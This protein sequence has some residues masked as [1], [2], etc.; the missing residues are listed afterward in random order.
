MTIGK[1]TSK[2]G[3]SIQGQEMIIPICVF[4]EE[5]RIEFIGTGFFIANCGIFVTA[6][7][8]I[9]HLLDENGK[10]PVDA[11]GNS[12]AGLFTFHMINPKEFTARKICTGSYH[13]R[14][15]VAVGIAEKMINSKT[16]EPLTNKFLPLTTIAPQVG[17]DISTWAY[18]K[19]VT[20]RKFI[21]KKITSSVFT[22]PKVYGGKV[23]KEHMNR[24]WG[25][26]PGRCYQTSLDFEGGSSGGPVFDKNGRVFAVNSTGMGAQDE[27]TW[28]SHIQ[29]I[30]GL[31]LQNIQ[32][33]DGV[34]HDNITIKKLIEHKVIIVDEGITND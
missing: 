28:V 5:N 12:K 20:D 14:D 4:H 30:G 32:T 8:V 34:I 29:A 11:E 15:D 25:K 9:Q 2:N 7:H 17:D 26:L 23:E 19:G 13:K 21:G 27:V 6:A 10:P 33:P 16:G 31:T 3:K 22:K 18:P 24:G 1:F